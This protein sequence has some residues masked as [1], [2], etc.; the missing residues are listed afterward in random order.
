MATNSKIITDQDI[1]DAKNNARALAEL[2]PEINL[3]IKAGLSPANS[4]K[5]I[6]AKIEKLRQ[7]IKVYSGETWSP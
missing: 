1:Q 5:D 7:F 2:I 6:Q 3:A 4:E